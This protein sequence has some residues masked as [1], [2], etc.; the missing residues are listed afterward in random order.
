M[1]KRDQHGVPLV[2][3][4]NRGLSK[5]KSCKM[6]TKKKRIY[7]FVYLALLCIQNLCFVTWIK[8]EIGLLSVDILRGSRLMLCILVKF[9]QQFVTSQRVGNS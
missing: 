2:P 6:K 1:R 5:H 3:A 7:A 8:V 9:E 4:L